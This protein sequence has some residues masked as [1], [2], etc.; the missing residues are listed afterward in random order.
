MRAINH[1]EEIGLKVK[2]QILN[3]GRFLWVMVVGAI[4]TVG[5]TGAGSHS[6]AQERPMS[7]AGKVVLNA[8]VACA[9][10]SGKSI[11]AFAM[12]LPTGGG[13]V[14]SAVYK[15]AVPNQM[16][17]PPGF[18]PAPA[19]RSARA[20]HGPATPVLIQGTPNY[21]KL[22]I[23]IKPA[24]P[25]APPVRVEVNLPTDWN[26]KSLQFGGGY[27]GRLVTGLQGVI[28]AGPQTPLPLTQGYLTSGTDS[29]HEGMV[30]ADWALNDE[31]LTN[32]AYAA[33][34]K[35][36]DAAWF[37]AK[38]YYGKASLYSYFTGSSEGGHEAMTVA[39]R[40][41]T[42]FDGVISIDPV[43]NES[44]LQTFGD[45][46]GGILQSRPGGWL[47]GQVAQCVPSSAQG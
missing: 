46:V 3:D 40:F 22:L 25:K 42:D 31:A 35:T 17:V 32:F 11:P 23:D 8:Q 37:L 14:T 39:Q 36:H 18:D 28:D 27:N 20:G 26:G 30:P 24:D 7:A 15:T 29:G 47:D 1:R 33:Y 45:Y 41:P 5:L 2:M 6:Y 4:V 44:A 13:V 43:M 16:G 12:G 21:C 34:G 9:A 10:L 19:G 38:R